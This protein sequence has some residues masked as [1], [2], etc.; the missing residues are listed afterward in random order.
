MKQREYQRLK[1]SCIRF[2][3]DIYRED[4]R[5]IVFGEGNLNARIVL[6]GEAPG[7]QESIHGRPFVGQAGKNLKDFLDILQLKRESLYIT[8][9]VKFRPYKVN[10]ESGRK[11][12]RPPNREELELSCPWLLKELD[13]VDPEIVVTLGNIAL[14][15]M[16]GDGRKNIGSVHGRPLEVELPDAER[17][18]LLFPLYHPASIIYR[19][20]LRTTYMEDLKKLKAYLEA[21]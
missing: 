20:S 16:T 2:F 18:Y 21:H 12:N 13:L 11:T 1:Q 8:N 4:E 5:E 14:R 19:K 7:E 17:K 3:K 15:T 9:A 10:P 6:V